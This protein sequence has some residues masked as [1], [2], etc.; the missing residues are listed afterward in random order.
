MLVGAGQAAQIGTVAHAD[1]GHEEAHGLHRL[2]LRLHN[3]LENDNRCARHQ[4][5]R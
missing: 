1:A 5:Q 2:L 4:G 3:R